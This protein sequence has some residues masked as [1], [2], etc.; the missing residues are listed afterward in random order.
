MRIKVLQSLYAFFQSENDRIDLGEKE[1]L[2]GLNK[3]YE[4]FIY[5]LSL[6]IEIVEFAHKRSEENKKKFFPTADDLNPNTRFIDNR[7][8]RQISTNKDFRRYYDVYKINW[9]DQEE[10]I[11]KLYNKIKMSEDY[12]TYMNN[13]ISAYSHEKEI[14]VKIIK[15]H[16]S[17]SDTLQSYYEEKSIHWTDDFHTA[18]LLAIKTIKGFNNSFNKNSKMPALLKKVELD[19]PDEDLQ[20]AKVLFR[21]TIIKSDE[22]IELIDLKVKNWE[23]DRI[24]VMDIIILKMALT[25]LMEFPSIPIKVTLNEYIE[26]AKMY[27]TPKSKV[28]VNGILDKLI[29]DLKSDDKI[30]K[31][32]RGLLEN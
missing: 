7:I 15:K 6:L 31:T 2:R 16:V 11:R 17:R 19:D 23:M 22:Y 24:A 29:H 13:K 30:K 28:F 20:F 12:K 9:A 10:M 25:E 26:L 21:K 5:Q 32:G 8:S 18:N 4:L 14:L 3:I 1:L 27:S